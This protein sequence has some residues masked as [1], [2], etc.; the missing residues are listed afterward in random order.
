MYNITTHF[1]QNYVCF[2]RD[3]AIHPHLTLLAVAFESLFFIEYVSFI[4]YD[5][6]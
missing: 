2:V 4:Y 3:F 6:H 1:I 5:I